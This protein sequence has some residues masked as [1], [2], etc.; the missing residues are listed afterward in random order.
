[1]VRVVRFQRAAEVEVLDVSGRPDP[2]ADGDRRNARVGP[3]GPGILQ[4]RGVSHGEDPL[5]SLDL[6][7]GSDAEGALLRGQRD[8]GDPLRRADAGGPDQRSGIDPLVPLDSGQG[9]VLRTRL[10][11]PGAEMDLDAPLPEPLQ[12]P[13]SQGLV[14]AAQ[15][16]VRSIRQDDP[17]LGDLVV[18]GR[19]D[20]VEEAVDLAGKLHAGRTR[21]RDHERRLATAL[22][23]IG[24]DR[25][26]L[27]RVHDPVANGQ[28]VVDRG[29]GEAPGPELF[30]AEESGRGT[31][32]QN[33]VVVRKLGPFR[34]QEPT[35]RVDSPDRVPEEVEAVAPAQDPVRVRDVVREERPRRYLGQQGREREVVL[36]VHERDP[37]ALAGEL[38][39]G[40]IDGGVEPSESAPRDHD[41]GAVPSAVAAGHGPKGPG[42]AGRAW[43]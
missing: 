7:R 26:P 10:H 35:V 15:D 30:V 24:L 18:V 39:P 31:D 8:G 11:D 34:P 17:T 41:A 6:E 2:L 1:M 21:P 37:G 13:T 40:H 42:K 32:R 19:Q 20:L 23:G 28:G 22:S 33:Q 9:H 29:E 38:R 36:P 27:H 43:R 3:A 16:P 4:D 12:A 25:G 14:P 5:P